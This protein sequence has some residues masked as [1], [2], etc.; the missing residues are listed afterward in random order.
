MRMEADEVIIFAGDALTSG[1]VSM[2][3]FSIDSFDRID[4]AL[5][6]RDIAIKDNLEVEAGLGVTPLVKAL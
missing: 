4:T 3:D 2:E 1:R 5:N 6:S